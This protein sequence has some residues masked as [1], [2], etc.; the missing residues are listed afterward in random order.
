MT[1][2]DS[3]GA[4]AAFDCDPSGPATTMLYSTHTEEETDR[5][6]DGPAG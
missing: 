5:D 6:A 4:D 1:I 2:S 3:P